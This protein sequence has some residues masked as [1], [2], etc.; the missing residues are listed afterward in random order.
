M[1]VTDL[2]VD[3]DLDDRHIQMWRQ[4]ICDE[5]LDADS[6]WKATQKLVARI[7]VSAFRDIVQLDMSARDAGL[8]LARGPDRVAR[9]RRPAAMGLTLVTSGEAH[10]HTRGR[11]HVVRTGELCLLS[12][13]EPFEKRL[14]AGYSELFL[15]LPV[16][17]ALAL[18]RPVPELT[19]HTLI[20]PQRGLG[21]MLAD[22]MQSLRRVRNEMSPGEWNAALGAVFELAAGVFG[23]SEPE[24]VGVA[25]REVQRSRALRYIEAHLADPQLSPGV[26]AAGVGMSLRYLHLLFEQGDSVGATIL[27]RRLE[28]CRSVLEDTSDKRSISEVAYAWGFNDAAHFS[29]TFRA[30]FGV[31]PREIRR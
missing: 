27:A 19:Q 7:E 22:G 29:R 18:G 3:L 12:S 1:D 26:I 4:Q 2:A 31:S 6:P 13:V 30:R 23:R 24:R 8:A 17:V 15:Y 28:C 20:A 10:L 11:D 14:S 16:P 9:E 5:M 21:S 25:T